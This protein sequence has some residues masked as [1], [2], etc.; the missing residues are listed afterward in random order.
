MSPV[1]SDTLVT[2]VAHAFVG[3]LCFDCQLRVLVIPV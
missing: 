1:E 2:F 3:A